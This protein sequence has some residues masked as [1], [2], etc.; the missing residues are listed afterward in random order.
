[1]TI[2]NR[3]KGNEAELIAAEYLRKKGYQV[4][5]MN[6]QHGHKEIDIVAVDGNDL[7]IV[8]V[9]MRESNFFENP[10]DAVSKQKI[11]F[12][13]DAAE[14]YQEAYDLF[15]EIRFD[16]VAITNKGERGVEIEHFEDAFLPPLG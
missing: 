15:N 1:M 7:V 4:L 5:H 14:A 11:R 2:S 12:L 8:E 6:W 16:V 9:K 3:A 13:C 10:E